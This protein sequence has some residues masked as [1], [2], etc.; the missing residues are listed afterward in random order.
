MKGN[1]IFFIKSDMVDI[2]PRKLPATGKSIC[3]TGPINVTS[4][5]CYIN[6]AVYNSG[7]LADHVMNAAVVNVEEDDVFHTGKVLSRSMSICTL[8]HDWYWEG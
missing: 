8:S 7:V 4:G 1:R 2:V 3:L 5:N 6:V